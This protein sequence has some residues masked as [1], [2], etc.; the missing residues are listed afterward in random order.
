MNQIQESGCVHN[1]PDKKLTTV[2]HS[3]VGILPATP[4]CPDCISFYK[5][6]TTF[7]IISIQSKPN[8]DFA[9]GFDMEDIR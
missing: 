1:S 2:Q 4:L 7:K 9:E 8:P 5:N 6:S 3:D